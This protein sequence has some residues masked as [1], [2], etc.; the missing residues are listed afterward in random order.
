[1]VDG[2]LGDVLDRGLVL[3]LALDELRPEAPAEDVVDASVALVESARVPAVEVTHAVGEVRLGRLDEQVI[4][5]AHQAARV[6]APTIAL[7][8][9]VQETD[10]EGAVIV[11]DDDRRLVVPPRRDVVQRAR[12][13]IAPWSAH[14]ATVALAGAPDGAR[15]P[16]GTGPLR[17]RHVPGTGPD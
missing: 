10:E 5:V 2:V 7:H 4:V 15:A 6:K 8:H 17:L 9:A 13:E 16:S 14:A 3:I 1:V 11:V 12:G